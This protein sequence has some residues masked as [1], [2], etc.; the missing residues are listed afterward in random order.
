VPPVE[1]HT[2]APRKLKDLALMCR[3]MSEASEY[4]QDPVTGRKMAAVLYA[5]AEIMALARWV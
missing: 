2:A 3:H 4:S 1:R 5:K